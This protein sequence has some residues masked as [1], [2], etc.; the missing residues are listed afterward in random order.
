MEAFEKP[1]PLAQARKELEHEARLVT[2]LAVDPKLKSFLNRAFDLDSDDTMWL[3]SV[4][5]LL[6]GKP[7]SEWGD[8][9]LA[10]FEVQLTSIARSFRHFRVLAFE[11]E[12]QGVSL[13]DG[14]PEM[15]RVS[16]TLPHSGDFEKVVQVPPGC[17]DRA[18]Q[19]QDDFRGMLDREQLFGNR[20][21]RVAVLAQL[22]QQLLA[23][24]ESEKPRRKGSPHT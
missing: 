3:E 13:L 12:S 17:R 11:M 24:G 5:N 21:V 19:M 8:Q 10:R 9:D 4:G 15:L 23:E 18:R 2:H 20:E 22:V 16:V 14:D 1:G 6:A 7:P